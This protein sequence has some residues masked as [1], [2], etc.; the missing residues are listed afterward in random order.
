MTEETKDQ[1]IKEEILKEQKPGEVKPDFEVHG[2]YEQS[3][4]L[5][6]RK[7]KIDVSSFKIKRNGED[8]LLF[9]VSI[10]TPEGEKVKMALSHADISQLANLINSAK[11]LFD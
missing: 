2:Q 3:I 10:L 4:Y 7:I 1:I 8:E 11:Y 6:G 9:T 5:A